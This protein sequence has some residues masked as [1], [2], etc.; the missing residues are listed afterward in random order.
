[1]G[2]LSQFLKYKSICIQC[3]NNPDPDA[4]ASALGLYT[5]FTDHGIDTRI[6]YGGRQSIKKKNLL[7]MMEVCEILAEHIVELPKTEL[8]MMVDAQYG[9]GN[10]Q[11]FEASE[12]AA[13]D[14]HTLYMEK[15]DKTFIDNT[16]QSCSTIVWELLKEEGYSVKDNRKLRIAFLYGL[17][18]DTSSY[19]DLYKEKDCAMRSELRDDYPELERLKKSC[20]T[21]GDLMIAGDALNNCY[22]NT[23]RRYLIISAMHCEQSILGII[24]DMAIMVDAAK[25]SVSFTDVDNGY[26]ISVRS[27]DWDYPANIVAEKLC[28]NIGNGGGHKD[29]AGGNISKELMNEKY[30]QQEITDV[31]IQRMNEI[32]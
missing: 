21:V 22:F 19:V 3:H 17:Y 5:F 9:Q 32:M 7:Y 8:L 12:I 29:K 4:L 11:I 16:Y 2:F 20:M 14:H 28:K 26:Q 27:C 6:V 18:T 23:E 31:I 15:T 24:G 1:M 10:A 13:V 25:V 30:G